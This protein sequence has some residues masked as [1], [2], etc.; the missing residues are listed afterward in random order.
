MFGLEFKAFFLRKCEHD[1][2]YVAAWS[3]NTL[4]TGI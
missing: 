1:L 3:D 4:T 2:L